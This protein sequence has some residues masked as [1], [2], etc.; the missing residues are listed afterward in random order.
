MKFLSKLLSEL[1]RN[2][3]K[4]QLRDAFAKLER[5]IED[6]EFQLDM[7]SPAIRDRFKSAP[8]Y[9]KIPNGCGP[10]GFVESNPIPVN[11][12]IGEISYLSRLEASLGNRLLFHRLGSVERVDVFEA[13]TFDGGNWYIL[14][15]DM[16]HS[17]R[18]RLAPEGL[19]FTKDVP[20]FSGF[21]QFCKNFPY[22]FL[23]AKAGER[24]SGLSIAYIPFSLISD[25]IERRVYDRPDAHKTKLNILEQCLR[26]VGTSE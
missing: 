14:Y 24:Q 23:E 5:V 2:N 15:L 1:S 19:L 21:T 13:V 25:Q 22:D 12:P 9:D 7:L 18:S 16:Y 8:A 4:A 3:E 11:G 26:R 10:F 17:R 20:Q 6:E